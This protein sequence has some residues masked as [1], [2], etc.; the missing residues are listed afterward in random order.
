MVKG[1]AVPRVLTIHGFIHADTRIAGG[2][3]AWLRSRL[4]WR[5]ERACWAEQPH[6]ISISP[7]VRERLGGIAT[8]VI[9]DIENPVAEEFFGVS[10]N[11]RP[12]TVFS[13]ALIGP[14]KN[15]LA[16]L[17][18][19]AR[20][21][22]A[23]IQAELRL[24]GATSNADYGQRVRDF[25]EARGLKNRVVLLGGIGADQVREELA[26]ASVFALVSLEEG[27]PMGIAEAMAEG[28]PVVASN[29]CGMPYMVRDG[30]SGCLVDPCNPEDIARRLQDLLQGNALRTRMGEKARQFALDRFHPDHVAR[31]TCDVYERA[32]SNHRTAR[33]SAAGR[34]VARTW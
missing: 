7:Y 17:T 29:R 27:A 8:G 13:A 24:A 33:P 12:G 32:I 6:I 15:T 4:W 2:R 19:F 9:H 1:M 31:R 5:S 22:E 26:R 11:E 23:G 16:L 21:A 30:E 25:I 34:E 10:R 18:A 14:R 3:F 20:V 28:V